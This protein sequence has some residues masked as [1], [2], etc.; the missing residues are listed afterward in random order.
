MKTLA[1]GN[2]IPRLSAGSKTSS[3]IPS[4]NRWAYALV[5]A[6]A[7][8]RLCFLNFES[9]DYNAFLSRWYDHIKSHGHFLAFKDNFSDYPLLY[10]YLLAGATLVPLKKIFAIKLISI[11]FDF[12]A[13]WL[14]FRIV[15]LKYGRGYLALAA[16]GIVLLL[17]TA[18]LNSSVWGQCDIIYT[19]ALLA[20][21]YCLMLGR[22]VPSM[23]AYG[24]AVCFKPQA[25]FFAPFVAGLLLSKKLSW[26]HLFIP[27]AVWLLV[28]VPAIL[29][30]KPL[31]LVFY[32]QIGKALGK[33]AAAPAVTGPQPPLTLGAPNLYSWIPDVDPQVFRPIGWMLAAVGALGLSLSMYWWRKKCRAAKEPIPDLQSTQ[34]HSGVIP[35]SAGQEILLMPALLSLLLVPYFLPGTH[36]RYFF[37]ADLFSV[38]YVFFFPRRWVVALWI[39]CASV[40]SYLPYLF[41]V[42]I[43]PL[44][45]L[46][47]VM[48]TALVFVA[49]HYGREIKQCRRELAE[50]TLT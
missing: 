9:G 36:E 10:L 35:G 7:L 32:N 24:L 15:S 3:P 22:P 41:Q 40:C 1:S 18:V 16:A 34:N 29:L 14:V 13:A 26:R 30:G 20:C 38:V 19:S 17:P 49:V 43:V 44:S 5:V 48:G 23:I 8:V 37:A 33:A 6:A 45:I 25:L 4:L 46:G 2:E 39:Q 50:R 42:R 28:P 47:I 11:A 31:N 27:V 21:F 12:V